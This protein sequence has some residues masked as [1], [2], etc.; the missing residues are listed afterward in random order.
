M[1]PEQLVAQLA[2]P[3]HKPA[4]KLKFENFSVQTTD[5]I[6]KFFLKYR[7]QMVRHKQNKLIS[8]PTVTVAEP[9]SHN[10]VKSGSAAF[11]I[12]LDPDRTFHRGLL[13]SFNIFIAFNKLYISDPCCTGSRVAGD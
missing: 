13:F 9:D 4:A 10:Y 11:L 2:A 3:Q 5:T 6:I 7:T 8:L 12:E 1:G